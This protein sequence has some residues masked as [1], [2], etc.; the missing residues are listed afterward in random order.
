MRDPSSTSVPVAE[1]VSS[2]PTTIPD[3]GDMTAV[4]IVGEVFST[5]TVAVA[6]TEEPEES[7]AEAVQVTDEPTLVSEAVT[8]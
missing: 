7:D 4:V 5:V 2:D 8:A 1:Q 6:L 3:V